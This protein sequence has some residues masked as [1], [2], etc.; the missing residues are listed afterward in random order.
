MSKLHTAADM[1]R[2]LLSKKKYWLIP[3]VILMLLLGLLIVFLQTSILA[4]LLYPLI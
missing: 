1:I 2:F 4:P 3:F